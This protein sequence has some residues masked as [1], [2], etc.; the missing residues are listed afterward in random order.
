MSYCIHCGQPMEADARF[1]PACGKEAAAP[2][3][4]AYAPAPYA[5]I[6]Y[7]PEEQACLDSFHR[8][9]NYE[10][11]AWKILGIILTV[12]GGIFAFFF[13]LMLVIGAA[14]GDGELVGLAV[15]YG[16][17]LCPAYL[18]MG[19][20]GI[21]CAG[22]LKKQISQIYTNAAPAFAHCNS[23]GMIVLSA[24]FNEIA[25]IFVIINFVRAKTNRALME[26]ILAKQ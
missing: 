5:S 21:V 25:L 9:M 4:P 26:Q 15:V 7:T 6:A 11:K 18:A 16:V 17:F 8:I 20:V 12:F 19:I 3:T 2:A 24:L 1:C 13:L 23:V 10:R 22:K 14:D